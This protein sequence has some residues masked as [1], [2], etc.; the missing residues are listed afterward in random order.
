MNGR[1]LST[2]FAVGSTLYAQT[3]VKLGVINCTTGT[4]APIGEY[5][6]NG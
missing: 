6:S 4:Q 5:I 3:T 1:F 2:L